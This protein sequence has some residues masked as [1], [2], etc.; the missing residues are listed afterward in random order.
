[1]KRLSSIFLFLLFIIC[2]CSKKKK[3]AAENDLDAA[4]SFIQAALEG[5]FNEARAYMLNDSLNNNWMDIAERNYQ[6]ADRD[7]KVGYAGASINIHEVNHPSDSVSV[8]IYSN[9]F[10]NDHDTLKVI[11]Q[12]EKWL[13]DLKYLFLHDEDTILNKMLNPNTIPK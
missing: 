8:V 1:M 5:K 6:K 11:K 13:I 3:P 7:T 2:A 4:R 10:K 9:S 12:N